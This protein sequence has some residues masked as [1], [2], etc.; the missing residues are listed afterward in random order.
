MSL[1]LNNVCFIVQYYIIKRCLK[2]GYR[3]YM[4]YKIYVLGRSSVMVIVRKEQV[5]ERSI[6]SVH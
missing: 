1:Y 4:I 3:P 2:F 6:Q 5:H